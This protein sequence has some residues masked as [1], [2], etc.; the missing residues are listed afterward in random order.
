MCFL[1][2]EFSVLASTVNGTVQGD[3]GN[4]TF[5]LTGGP[6]TV[7]VGQ[8]LGGS[9][10]DTFDLAGLTL[11]Q[12]TSL[13]G[14]TETDTLRGAT[15]YVVTGSN[16]GTSNGLSGAGG[17]WNNVENITG[18]AG[19]DAFTFN[20]G[21]TLTG[22][23]SGLGDIDFADSPG[24]ASPADWRAKRDALRSHADYI[25]AYA[26]RPMQFAPGTRMAYD[27]YGFIVLG[28]ILERVSGQDYD[29]VLRTEVFA[30]SG[31]S[32][33]SDGADAPTA[34]GY[35]RRDGRWIANDDLLPARATA[36]GGIATTADDLLAFA[37]ALLDGR[38]LSSAMLAEATRP[39]NEAGWYGLGFV[40]VGDGPLFR[41]GHAGD[42]PGMNADVRIFPA[43]RTVLIALSNLDP[44]SGY[45]PFRWFEP[46][47]PAE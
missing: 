27:N 38:L 12:S 5:T 10:N 16:T 9:G 28:R 4:D 39:Q 13:D 18:T 43:T 11:A 8:L 45:Q 21:S 47:M 14:G 20:N 32:A 31:M 25:A 36:A 37:R 30:P 17:V 41:Y 33:T 7:T 35:T 15:S 6:G 2:G 22:T 29:A 1:V 3:D 26:A 23:A 44:P 42:F 46:R 34:I 19:Q 40:R 24:I